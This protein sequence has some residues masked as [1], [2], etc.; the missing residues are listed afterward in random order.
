MVAVMIKLENTHTQ[1]DDGQDL[2]L[3]TIDGMQYKLP[4]DFAIDLITN[5]EERKD[6]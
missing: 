5:L 1:N 6:G 3:V 2:Y 4:Y